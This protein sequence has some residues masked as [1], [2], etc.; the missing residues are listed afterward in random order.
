MTQ[1]LT[2]FGIG[3]H[4]ILIFIVVLLVMNAIY[5]IRQQS[6]ISLL[7]HQLQ[8]LFKQQN[9]ENPI[10]SEVKDLAKDPKQKIAAIKLHREQNPGMSIADAKWDVENLA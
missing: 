3:D 9:G 10:S 8:I 6:R 2:I 4:R 7:E 5:A 1:L